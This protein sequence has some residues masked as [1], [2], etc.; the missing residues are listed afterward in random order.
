MTLYAC[1]ACSGEPC[2]LRIADEEDPP[3]PLRCPFGRDGA[4]RWH[5]V[6]SG[7]STV[8]RAGLDLL[9]GPFVEIPATAIARATAEGGRYTIEVEALDRLL[10]PCSQTAFQAAVTAMEAVSRDAVQ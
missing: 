8:P 5:A 9:P 1:A 2:E 6:P 10:I 3:V 7:R 4:P